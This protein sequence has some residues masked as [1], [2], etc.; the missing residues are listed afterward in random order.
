MGFE[1]FGL[2]FGFVIS[3]FWDFGRIIFFFGVV[4]VI[5]GVVGRWRVGKCFE[6]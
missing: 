3:F 5:F 4:I 1:V 2:G 6:N